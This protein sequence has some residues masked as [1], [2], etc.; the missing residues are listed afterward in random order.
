MPKTQLI[1]IKIDC[2]WLWLW[3]ATQDIDN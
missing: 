1:E 3:Q 2:S